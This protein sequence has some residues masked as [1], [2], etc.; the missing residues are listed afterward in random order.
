V[1]P[2]IHLKLSAIAFGF[3]ILA[4][5]AMG[6]SASA[7]SQ[8]LRNECLAPAAN[9]PYVIASD[10]SWNM[11]GPEMSQA[12]DRSYKSPKR[13]HKR[14]YFDPQS[15]TWQAPLPFEDSNGAAVLATIPDNFTKNITLHIEKALERGYAEYVFF[16]DMGHSHFFLPEKIWNK[17][18]D[19]LELPAQ[20]VKIYEGL[21]SEPELKVLYHT[22]EQLKFTGEDQKLINDSWLQ[23]RY[24]TRNILG[25]NLGKA[26]LDILFI[27]KDSTEYNTVRTVDKHFYWSSGFNIH[28][29]NQ[30]C[31]SYNFKGQ[32]LYF[33]ISFEDLPME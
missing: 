9:E 19:H 10:F 4:S 15:K 33:D 14:F 26:L 32:T 22:G 6:Q 24:Y 31:F 21:T 18:Y 1:N 7:Q 20:F 3:A 29:S 13:L 28:A 11:T 30:G 27:G 5:S 17:K 8:P 23:W 25:D 12:F 16:P 2:A